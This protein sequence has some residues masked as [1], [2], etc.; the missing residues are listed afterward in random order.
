MDWVAPLISLSLMEIVLGIDNVIFIAILVT[1]LPAEQQNLA[2]QLGLGLALGMRLLLLFAISWIMALEGTVFELTDLGIPESLYSQLGIEHP[3]AI[4]NITGKDLV[5]LIGGLFLIAKSVHE[6]HVKLE[7][8]EHTTTNG[9]SPAKAQFGWILFQII[10]L[11]IVFSLDSV[12][13]AVGMAQQIW[14]MVVAMVIA[15]G[16]MLIFSGAI[17]RFVHRHPT[18]KILA[19]SF[20]ILIG[21]LLVAEGTGS[22]L[23]RGYVYFAMAFSLIVE[24]INIRIRSNQKPV[25]L[26]EP[27]PVNN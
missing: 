23:D 19:L 1:R 4:N 22:H 26:R 18:I 15:V 8:E 17:S 25:E 13:T 7:G 3:E 24:L 9:G 12:I 20:L 11:D 10:M 2:R 5:L 27:P 21:V 14:I 6:I 16:V